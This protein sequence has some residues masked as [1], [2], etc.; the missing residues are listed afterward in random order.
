MILSKVGDFKQKV[1]NE[2]QSTYNWLTS[3]PLWAIN[4]MPYTK[5]VQSTW[6]EGLSPTVT[7]IVR[8]LFLFIS[9]IVTL[10]FAPSCI[11]HFTP[12]RWNAGLQ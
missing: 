7:L 5:K 9:W 10:V 4:E 1:A 3:S 8:Y 2:Q 12:V 11:L 6:C